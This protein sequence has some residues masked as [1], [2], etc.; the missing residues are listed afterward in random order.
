MYRTVLLHKTQ[1]DLHCFVCREDQERPLVDYRIT[2]LTFGVS[3]SSF[4]A[5]MAMKQNALEHIDTHPHAVQVVLDSFYV[6][7]GLTSANSIEEAVQLRKQLQELFALGGFVLH[8]WKCSESAVAERIPS[9]LLDKKPHRRSL[10]PTPS[11][12]FLASSA[13]QI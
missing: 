10:A 6:D 5:N 1:R 7:D 8:K 4:A 12:R 3:A 2:R 13:M 9:H 11:P